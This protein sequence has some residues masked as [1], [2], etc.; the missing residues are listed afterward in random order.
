MC[1][2]HPSE[3]VRGRDMSLVLAGIAGVLIF[4]GLVINGTLIEIRDALRD[5][6]SQR[7]TAKDK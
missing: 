2:A 1:G 4:T 7:K 5:L 3:E 6:A